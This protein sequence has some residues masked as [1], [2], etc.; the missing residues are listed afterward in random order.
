MA[1]R[2]Y[3]TDIE[4]F[5]AVWVSEKRDVRYAVERIIALAKADDAR[6]PYETL[7]AYLKSPAGR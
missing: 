6:K 4:L 2:V 3:L 5:D 1:R 7:R